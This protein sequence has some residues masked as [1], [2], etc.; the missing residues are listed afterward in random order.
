MES[1]PDD[2]MVCLYNSFVEAVRSGGD[3]SEFSEDDLIDIFDYASG[4]PDDAIAAETI[5]QGARYFPS[6]ADLL[7]R[8]A[9]LF[10][11]L[12]QE[13]ACQEIIGRLPEKSFLFQI[14]NITCASGVK[15][16]FKNII[17]YLDQMPAGRVE[18][19]DIMYVVDYFDSLD[20]LAFVADHADSLSRVSEYPST[21]YNEL[22]HLYWEKGNYSKAAEFGRKVTEIEPFNGNAWTELAD[23][24]NIQIKD[25]Q[26]AVECADFALAIDP[27]SLGAMVVKSSALYESDPDESRR[28]VAGLVDISPSDPLVLY[29]EA[30]LNINDGKKASGIDKLERAL[31]VAETSQYRNIFNVLLSVIESSLKPG[32]RSMMSDLFVNDGSIDAVRWC[33]DLLAD[34]SYVG[35]YEVFLSANKS[36]RFDF[37][38]QNAFMVATEVL[39]RMGYFAGVVE[40][41]KSGYDGLDKNMLH[42]PIP[43]ALMYALSRYRNDK[44]DLEEIRAYLDCRITL[45]GVEHTGYSL[46]YRLMNQSAIKRMLAFKEALDAGREPDFGVVD[47]LI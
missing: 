30:I 9:F 43:L 10:H 34:G 47:P 2:E 37:S 16:S 33:S 25:P 12:G 15:E 18:D 21:I 8:K 3:M 11:Q 39:Y 22:F 19:G 41:L 35:A 44:K 5:I 4:I 7:K 14:L 23:L 26:A 28:V 20:E 46:S 38:D 36:H 24:Y 31:S 13:S 40:L 6:S 42:L 17:N 29:A 45:Y 1:Y 27:D 32:L